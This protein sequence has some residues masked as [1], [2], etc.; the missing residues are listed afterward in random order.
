MLHLMNESD[1]GTQNNSGWVRGTSSE[2]SPT[3]CKKLNVLSNF[4]VNVNL[5]K[6]VEG[7][8]IF[9]LCFRILYW[10]TRMKMK[11]KVKHM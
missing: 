10:P 4:K 3:Q 7:K 2:V 11:K 6:C 5:F 1:D 9:Q 8:P